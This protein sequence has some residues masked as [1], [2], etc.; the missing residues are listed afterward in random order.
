M[1]KLILA[2]QEGPK[3]TFTLNEVIVR[4]LGWRPM[5]FRCGDI[6]SSGLGSS[7]DTF[8]PMLDLE[9]PYSDVLNDRFHEAIRKHDEALRKRAEPE[10][11]VKKV[12]AIRHCVSQS[13]LA[14]D[15]EWDI[16]R[17]LEKGDDSEL[18]AD[19]QATVTRGQL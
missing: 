11:M 18:R 2:Q 8:P 13:E 19:F 6:N 3:L 14:K 12:N 15:Y 9:E 5:D 17:E 7:E 16:L 1:E 4:L 10:E